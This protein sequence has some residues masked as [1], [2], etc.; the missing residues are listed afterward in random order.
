MQN[1]GAVLSWA[2]VQWTVEI[3]GACSKS[4]SCDVVLQEFLVNNI[5]DSW[6]ESLDIL[7]AGDEGFYVF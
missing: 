3:C 2:L 7:G 1:L 4:A 6:Y 5:D